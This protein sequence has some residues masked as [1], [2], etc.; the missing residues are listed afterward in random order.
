VRA[1]AVTV[2]AEGPSVL[3]R[4]GLVATGVLYLLLALLTFRVAIE[5]RA[6]GEQPDTDGALRL[7]AEQPLGEVLMALLML[8]FAAHAVWRLAE[9]L[10]DRDHE[11]DEP[12]GLAKRF[13]YAALAVWY[14]A[15]AGLTGWVLFGNAPDSSG[16]PQQ[17]TRG[18]FGWPLG[19]ELIA[20]VGLGLIATAVAS[21]VFAYRERHLAKL[22]TEGMS[23]EALRIADLAGKAGYASRAVVFALIGGFLVEAAWTYD[24]HEARGL[25]GALLRLVH[26]PLGPVLLAAIAL[27]FACYGTWSLMQAR[28]RS[29]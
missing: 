28:Y 20:A 2:R 16:K 9:A 6:N 13:G 18:V 12:K 17:T 15:L 8:G 26:A 7:V 5:G 23:R 10:Q 22:H 14:A 27:G 24:P 19:R 29:V 21:V 11:G 1:E 25:D 4:V 3:G